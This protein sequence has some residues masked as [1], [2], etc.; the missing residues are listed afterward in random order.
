M[1]I[2]STRNTIC[3][4]ISDEF[5]SILNPI[6]TAR[7]TIMRG[8][9]E[10]KSLLANMTFSPESTINQAISDLDDEVSDIIP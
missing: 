8:V 7:Q 4:K 9:L 2:L 3:E 6:D 5:D 10:A 1:S